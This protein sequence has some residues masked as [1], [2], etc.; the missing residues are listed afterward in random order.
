[1]FPVPGWEPMRTGFVVN[2]NLGYVVD[3]LRRYSAKLLE[4]VVRFSGLRLRPADCVVCTSIS[5][6]CQKFGA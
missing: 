1:M 4:L 2:S 3:I 5:T 6:Q